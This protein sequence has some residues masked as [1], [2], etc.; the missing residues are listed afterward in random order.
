MTIALAIETGKLAKL[1]RLIFGSDQ[2][3]EITAAVAAVKR[4][5]A[6]SDL[7]AHWLADVV[8]RGA[9]PIAVPVAADPC[10]WNDDDM[11]L[12]W[13]AWHRRDR[14]TPK[15]AS[16]VERLT[17]WRGTISDRQRRWLRDIADRLSA[18]AA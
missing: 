4:L 6:A 3:G 10:P 2:P 18:V 15:E 8:E 12:V 11:S 5:L 9:V 17:R 1:I 14:L 16:F 7:D 13:F